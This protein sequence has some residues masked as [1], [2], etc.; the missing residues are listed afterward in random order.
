M[1]ADRDQTAEISNVVYYCV[2][3]VP[4][5]MTIMNLFAQHNK[6]GV[7]Y[8]SEPLTSSPLT[9]YPWNGDLPAAAALPAF[10]K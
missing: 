10:S 7:D 8:I 1:L 9:W 3:S 4:L 2:L 5:E 6:M